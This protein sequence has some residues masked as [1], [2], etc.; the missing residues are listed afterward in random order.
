MRTASSLMR[1][2]RETVKQLREKLR[3][4]GALEVAGCLLTSSLVD[5]LDQ[6]KLTDWLPSRSLGTAWFDVSPDP[7]ASLNA[8]TGKLV[9]QWR[10]AGR[11]VQAKIVEGEQFWSTQEISLAPSLL[12]ASV[13][14]VEGG[15]S[16]ALIDNSVSARV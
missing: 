3:N 2:E 11:D 4:D 15:Q 13:A 10:A 16:D 7:D 1:G 9:E 14:F 8:T 6:L 12:N 5:S